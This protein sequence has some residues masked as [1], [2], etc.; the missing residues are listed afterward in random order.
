MI[1]KTL[2]SSAK[3]AENALEIL[4]K[5]K[6][7]YEIPLIPKILIFKC[8]KEPE[9]FIPQGALTDF[10]SDVSIIAESLSEYGIIDGIN[11]I[12]QMKEVPNKSLT[13]APLKKFKNSQGQSYELDV[14][15]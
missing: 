3:F 15:V 8:K 13:I 12:S 1:W 2:E 11:Y 6:K 5:I 14:L 9:W 10:K 7:K 4:E